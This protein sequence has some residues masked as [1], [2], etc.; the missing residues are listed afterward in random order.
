MLRTAHTA[1]SGVTST[2]IDV[3]AISMVTDVSGVFQRY[4]TGRRSSTSSGNEQAAV[5]RYGAEATLQSNGVIDLTLT[6]KSGQSYCCPDW[7]CHLWLFDG[8]RWGQLRRAAEAERVALPALLSFR[9]TA[10]IEEGALFYDTSQPE[11]EQLDGRRYTATPNR[12][13]EYDEVYEGDEGDPE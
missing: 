2:S 3:S 1:V 13:E 9:I 8:Y 7:K 5:P 4:L 10:I 11:E 6:F 12:F